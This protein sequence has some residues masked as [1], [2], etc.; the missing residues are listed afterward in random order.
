MD[1]EVK[2]RIAQFRFGVIADLVGARRLTR[3]EKERL[4]RE[5]SASQW[6]IPFTGR[7]YISPSTIKRWVRLYDAS[8]SRLE[9]LY[10]GDRAD[11]GR[12]RAID[13]ET[14]LALVELR[15][16]S[17]STTLPVLLKEAQRKGI[18]S[19]DLKASHATIYRLFK[20]HGVMDEEVSVVDRRKFEA[21]LPNDIWQADCLHGPKVDVDGRQRKSYLFAFIDDMS[22]LIPHAEFYHKE[23]IESFLDCLN[24]AF[25]KRGLP[26]KLYVDNGPTFRSYHLEH[27]T[28][29]LGIALIHSKPYQPEGRGKIER[30]FKTIRM[31]VLSTIPDGL[32]LEELNKRL[33]Q[34]VDKEYHHHEHSST[35]QTPLKRYIDHIH[36]VR[37]APGDLERHFRKKVNRK[38]SKDRSISL[39]ERLYEAP[40]EL[41]GRT[42]ALLYHENDPA[43]IEA[44]YNNKSYGMLI[45]IDLNVNCRVKRQREKTEIIVEDGNQ[46]DTMPEDHYRGGSLFGGGSKDD[47]EL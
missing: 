21:E 35:K 23:N 32:S 13:E 9:S 30:L 10:P 42:V 6:D 24:K 39:M 3:G 14:A 43:R 22:R 2:K 38:V 11:R 40:V 12:P 15:R 27:I 16:Q 28:A 1:E 26:R 17:R 44:L 4:I 41:I 37:E 36:L 25:S 7:S 45:P 8:G 46:A 33:T 19:I 34:W 18:V 47:V 29:S 5:K 20:T 31:Q